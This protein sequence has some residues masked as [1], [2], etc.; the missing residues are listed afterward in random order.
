M[1]ELERHKFEY[2]DEEHRRA[3]QVGLVNDTAM[4]NATLAKKDTDHK[5]KMKFLARSREECRD[6]ALSVAVHTYIDR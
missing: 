3:M 1:R 6:Q 2:M 5:H 4:H